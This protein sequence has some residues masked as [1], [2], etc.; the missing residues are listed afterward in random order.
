[1]SRPNQKSSDPLTVNEVRL[2]E[3][4]VFFSIAFLYQT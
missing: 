2:K 3:Y 1:M 4:D